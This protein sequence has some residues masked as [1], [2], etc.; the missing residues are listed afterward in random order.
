MYGW[1]ILQFPGASDITTEENVGNNYHLFD[2]SRDLPKRV[3]F[4][5][6]QI[7]YRI[8]GIWHSIGAAQLV[9]VGSGRYRGVMESLLIEV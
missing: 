3:G 6:D 9:Y 4:F 5:R 8:V 1:Q 2:H 7:P